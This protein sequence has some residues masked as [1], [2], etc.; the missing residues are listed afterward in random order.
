MADQD[1][2]W[3]RLEQDVD[4]EYP[5]F[6]WYPLPL[7]VLNKVSE[8]GSYDSALTQINEGRSIVR[9]GDWLWRVLGDP[10]ESLGVVLLSEYLV[11]RAPWNPLTVPVH[12]DKSWIRQQLLNSISLLV[13]P[14]AV[15]HLS[16]THTLEDRDLPWSDKFGRHVS[17][18]GESVHDAVFLLSWWDLERP[19]YRKQFSSQKSRI[20]SFMRPDGS[21][22]EGWWWLRSVG[23][24]RVGAP[25]VG[26]GGALGPDGLAVRDADVG[27]RPALWMNLESRIPG[28]P[29]GGPG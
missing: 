24:L 18:R 16:H 7:D 29:G 14:D 23:G 3:A 1:D 20:A 12:Y 25:V 15:P 4:P 8:D 9:L 28:S 22:I 6:M 27:V 26:R 21:L 2:Y 11:A 10:G 13:P 19:L 17:P 5:S